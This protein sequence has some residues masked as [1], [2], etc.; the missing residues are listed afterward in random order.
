[1]RSSKSHFTHAQIDLRPEL[2]RPADGFYRI[3]LSEVN[4]F[5]F[6]TGRVEVSYLLKGS[7]WGRVEPG[8]DA[9]KDT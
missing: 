9:D 5:L 2:N 4:Q 6:S 7:C 3:T 8:A 1:M